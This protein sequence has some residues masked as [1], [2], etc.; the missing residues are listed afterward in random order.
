MRPLPAQHGGVRAGQRAQPAQPP[1]NTPP[2]PVDQRSAHVRPD[3]PV[4]AHHG[5]ADPQQAGEQA[6]RVPGRRQI[7]RVSTERRDATP[8][9]PSARRENT[10]AA[11]VTGGDLPIIL[12]HRK[13]NRTFT[14]LPPVKPQGMILSQAHNTPS[15]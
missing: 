12:P 13:R 11:G 3:A 9:P 10:F 7:P 14:P 4:R 15:W 2:G 8:P 5:G 1:D 6:V